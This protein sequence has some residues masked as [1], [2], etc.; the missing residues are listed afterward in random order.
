MSLMIIVWFLM[1]HWHLNHHS[2][3]QRLCSQVRLVLTVQIQ[4]QHTWQKISLCNSPR[5]V[6]LHV[7]NRFIQQKWKIMTCHSPK[8]VLNTCPDETRDIYY[9]YIDSRVTIERLSAG[10]SH[11]PFF[12]RR[13]FLSC[14]VTWLRFWSVLRS[15]SLTGCRF[16]LG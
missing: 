6:Y 8:G 1:T 11:W 5:T 13:L 10:E 3:S 14:S 9:I 7:S 4:H 15:L 2:N 12:H 16:I